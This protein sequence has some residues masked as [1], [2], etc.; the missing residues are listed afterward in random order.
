MKFIQ[1]IMPDLGEEVGAIIGNAIGI[2]GLLGA[3]YF[4]SNLIRN[5]YPDHTIT[6]VTGEYQNRVAYFILTEDGIFKVGN[7]S[8]FDGETK[9]NS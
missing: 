9:N 6:K 5:F 1:A 3:V 8:L 7:G 4:S 2:A